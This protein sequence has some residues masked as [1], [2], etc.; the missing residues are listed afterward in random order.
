MELE[1]PS[2]TTR[3]SVKMVKVK[4][5]KK[6]AVYTSGRSLNQFLFVLQNLRER[7]LQGPRLCTGAGETTASVY[8]EPASDCL[9]LLGHNVICLS[10]SLIDSVNLAVI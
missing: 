8:A 4:K 9:C 6:N 3:D 7:L 2:Q 5:K 10:C 1:I